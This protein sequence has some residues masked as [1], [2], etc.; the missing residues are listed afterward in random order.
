[1]TDTLTVDVTELDQ[2]LT[3]A[4]AVAGVARSG[5]VL[6]LTGELGTGKTQFVRGL[7][8]GLGLDPGVISSPTF[9]LMQEHERDKP[10]DEMSPSVLVH[11][12]AYR[13]HGAE[14]MATLGW[15]GA[16]EALREGA[17]VA[18][19]WVELVEPALGPDWLAIELS[20]L[21]HGRRLRFIP[22]GAWH[23]RM[24]TLKQVI[25]AAGA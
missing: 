22:H 3:V 5:D 8:R 21:A 19:E 2:T 10:A 6:G 23:D 17:V 16:G 7:A 12:D 24:A 18:I 25:D 14:G 11:I 20:H 9:V 4:A 1:M 15:E 13:L